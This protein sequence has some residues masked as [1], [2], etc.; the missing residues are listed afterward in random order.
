MSTDPTFIAV[1]L[2]LLIMCA[3]HA[4]DSSDLGVKVPAPWHPRIMASLGFLSGVAQSVVQ[5]LTF[6]QAFIATGLQIAG[7]VMGISGI[8]ASKRVA[9]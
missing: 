4:L 8:A 5:G 9:Q 6:K 1:T 3:A 2:M 7:G